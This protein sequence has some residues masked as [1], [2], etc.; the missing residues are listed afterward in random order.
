MAKPKKLRPPKTHDR[1]WGEGTVREVRPGVWRAWRAR[2]TD[3]AGKTTRPSRTFTGDGAEQLA[4]VWA[5][6]DVQPAVL[7]LG[8]WLNRWLTLRKPTISA[9]TFNLYRRDVLACQPLAGRPI[10]EITSDEWQALAS[11]LLDRWSNYHV[12][13][14][15]GNISV[16][17]RAA[18]PTHLT[19]NTIVGVKLPREQESPPKAW[20]QDEVDRLLAEAAGGVHEPWLLFSLGTGVRLGEARALLWTDVDLAAKT[21]TIRASLD[22]G[23]STRGPTKTRRVRVIDIP[24]EV[25]THLAALRKRQPAGQTL[26]FG[27]TPKGGKERAYRPRSYRSWLFTRTKAAGVSDLPPHSLRHTCASLAFARRVPVPDVARQLGHSVETCQRTYAHYIN[28]G[29][30]VM[31]K[32]LG[33]S[34]RNRFSGPKQVRRAKNGTR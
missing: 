1:S 2:V 30:R 11:S 26:V 16:A 10:A 28:E 9:N 21:A 5:K 20:R 7:L 19:V 29:L 25:C 6:G 33:A 3:A 32:A 17:L 22:N 31:A 27:Y 13:I 14:W 4:K 24:D 23:R 18:M 12:R 8:D 34:L 15:K